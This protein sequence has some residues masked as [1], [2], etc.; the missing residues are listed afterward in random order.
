MDQKLIEIRRRLKD[1]FAFYS[2]SAVKIRTKSGDVRPLVLNKVQQKLDEVV[3]AQYKA[4]GKVRVIILKARQQGLSTYTSAKIYSRISQMKA[5][6]GLV[7]AHK[8]D[9]TRALFDMY[10]R[11]HA[12]MPELLKPSTRY[13]SRRELVFDK[14]DSGLIVATAGGDGIARGETITH[15]H[16]SEVA[17]WPVATA[18]DNLNALL[19]A[20]PNRK[21]TEVY[22]E[23]TANGMTG[24]FYELWQ[25]AVRGEN[26][27]I[28]FF[29]PWFDSDEYREPVPEGFER[30]YEEEELAELYGLDDEQLMFRRIKIAQT[31]REQFMQEYP[32][33][34]DEAFIT[35]GRPVFNPEQ[36]QELLR[37]APEPIA[38]M[39]VEDGV[40]R[41]HPR[42]ELLVYHPF[43]PAEVYTIGADV[44]MGVRDGDYSVAQILD[45][46]KRQVAVWRGLVHPDYFADILQALGI[47]YNTAR[48]APENNN[49]GI[50]TAVRL[51][52]D[53]A[54]P[55]VFTEVN[56]GKLNDQHT[57]AI[58][59]RTNVK[60]KP[61]IID[62]LRAAC[63]ECEIEINDKETLREMLSY[64]VNE[65]GQ[66]EAEPGNHDD[67]VMSLAIANHCHEG[68]FTPIHVTD[69]FYIEA[70]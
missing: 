50:L 49:H 2:R 32:S 36:I 8:A 3:E 43:D 5:K 1:E 7:V 45:S 66:M 4:T 69:D 9:S 40:L 21:D 28:P 22:V 56:E 63:R 46:R 67:C 27:F 25:G 70:I 19:Q 60:T 14:L 48:I 6:K 34:A 12:E 13:S 11:I 16:L 52:R 35:S 54:Y 37:N 57:I 51:G 41:E 24:V 29:S 65:A 33:C 62:R 31:S 39:A 64:I 10:Q 18:A 53:L 55:N 30:T 42:G 26:G 20:I 38:R 44:G 17:F 47:H 58:G 15:C 68:K 59:F 23:S 61:L